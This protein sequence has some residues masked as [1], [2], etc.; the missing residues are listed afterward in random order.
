[1]VKILALLLTGVCVLVFLAGRYLLNRLIDSA[2]LW[3]ESEGSYPAIQ[4]K[5]DW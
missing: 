5:E 4:K 1:M 3:L 2:Y